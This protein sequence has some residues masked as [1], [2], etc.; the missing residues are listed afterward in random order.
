MNKREFIKKSYLSDVDWLKWV[1]FGIF[2]FGLL[3][4]V[5]FV[6]SKSIW[7]DEVSYYNVQN[8]NSF[9][10]ILKGDYWVKDNPP[11]YFIIV[12][13]WMY[14]GQSIIW[15]RLF[16]VCLFVFS[17]WLLRKI[18]ARLHSFSSIIILF[19]FSFLPY[20][21]YVGY[22]ASPYNLT[23][24]LSI[25]IYYIFVKFN[26]G[27]FKGKLWSFALTVG[28]LSLLLFSSHYSS[29]YFI[30]G[31]F[32]FSCYF[33]I[34]NKNDKKGIL[35]SSAMVF[36][37]SLP[38][39]LFAMKNMPHIES[40]TYKPDLELATYLDLL[41]Y[42]IGTLFFRF[43]YRYSL[44]VLVLLFTITLK[45]SLKE[46][47]N[48]TRE[49]MFVTIFGWVFGGLLIMYLILTRNTSVII[50]RTHVVIYVGC[51][52]LFGVIFDRVFVI[53]KG[54]ER[55]LSLAMLLVLFAFSFRPYFYVLNN[56]IWGDSWGSVQAMS[57]SR[58]YFDTFYSDFLIRMK[59]EN[60]VAVLIDG[61]EAS[62]GMDLVVMLYCDKDDLRCV[63]FEENASDL[64][65]SSQLDGFLV[66]DLSSD[67][68]SSSDYLR[69]V[70]QIP[71]ENIIDFWDYYPFHL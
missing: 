1:V 44:V 49:F 27:F 3:V 34:V 29:V 25:L 4:R 65:K 55:T 31:Y 42:F 60:R 13:L 21:S 23:A 18:S 15:M 62:S 69:F 8:E 36:L 46:D 30:A 22:W 14:L 51:I 58:K 47:S 70:K 38:I 35:L 64:L 48:K 6:F 68:Y 67:D 17:Y 9:L 32:A 45:T 7:A 57:F 10:E 37:F 26:E 43:S 41:R 61:G 54:V 53:L 59:V 50:E 40:M 5:Y 16:S 56:P 11:G 28:L 24:F 71:E 66:V 12:K 63:N 20:F 19:L 39:F 52:L 2:I 33:L